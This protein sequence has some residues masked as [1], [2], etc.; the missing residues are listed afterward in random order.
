MYFLAPSLTGKMSKVLI[1]LIIFAFIVSLLF[2]FV[3][4]SSFFLSFFSYVSVGFMS[5]FWQFSMI[6][7]M[8]NVIYT[9]A[10][11]YEMTL[12]MVNI[13][14]SLHK[15]VAFRILQSQ[16]SNILV[17]QFWCYCIWGHVLWN[18]VKLLFSSSAISNY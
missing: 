14:W 12:Y 10:V 4:L 18:D 9:S 7:F 2:V 17:N 5:N 3:L 13:I 6:L 8:S 16:I 11:F 15:I 1:H